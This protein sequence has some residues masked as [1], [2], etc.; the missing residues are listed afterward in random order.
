MT[1]PKPVRSRRKA[2]QTPGKSLKAAILSTYDLNPAELVLL[3][4]AA[5]VTDT[6]TR[7]NTDVAAAET[8]TGK[9]SRGQT[10]ASPLLAAQR[11]HAETL[12]NLLDALRLPAPGEEEGESSTTQRARRA[13]QIRWAREKAAG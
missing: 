10:V 6:L 3:D 11:Q 12:A 13:A 5:E 9:G 7:L 4:Q 2:S 8:L 1:K